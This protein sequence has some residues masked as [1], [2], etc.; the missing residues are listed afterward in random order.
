[1]VQ[2][3]GSRGE[4]AAGDE[5]ALHIEE[6]GEGPLL[7]LAHGF[8]GSARNFRPQVRALRGSWRVRTYDARG[9]AR[10]EAPADPGAYDLPAMVGDLERVMGPEQGEPAVV[11]GLS[12]GAAVALQL[13]LARPE[14][15]RALVLAA[16][17]ADRDAAGARAFG[18]TFADAIDREGLEAA[19]E[20]HVWGPRS[21]LDAAGARLVRQGFLEH[22]PHALSAILRG[23][24]ASLPS[25]A[26]LV[27]RL[28]EVRAPVLLIAGEEDAPALEASRAL[29][30]G[31]PEARCEVIPDAGHVVNLARPGAFNA[32]LREFLDGLGGP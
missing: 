12:M 9:H 2:G 30:A 25:T 14:R 15:V 31:L 4:G 20:T 3:A 26:E 32:V 19:G 16:W 5:P 10:S 29:A 8:A 22:P 1:M 13:A 6:S 28:A 21:G 23:V 7:V 27:A 11:G 17:P 18:V 24:L